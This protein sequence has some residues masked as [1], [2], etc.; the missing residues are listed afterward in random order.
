MY[1]SLCQDVS[2]DLCSATLKSCLLSEARTTLVSEPLALSYLIGRISPKR[3]KLALWENCITT[4]LSFIPAPYG[5]YPWLHYKLCSWDVLYCDYFGPPIPQKTK[6]NKT[7]KSLNQR[8]KV[9]NYR[10]R[11]TQLWPRILLT[12]TQHLYLKAVLK[13]ERLL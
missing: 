10:S 3:S 5:S 2:K 7:T 12:L 11:I 6:Q 8:Q 4:R 9:L 1:S 13:A